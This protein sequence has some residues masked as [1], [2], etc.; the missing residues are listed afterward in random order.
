MVL[1]D[2]AVSLRSRN[3]TDFGRCAVFGIIFSAT[4]AKHRNSLLPVSC[5]ASHCAADFSS[6]GWCQ[7]EICC[8]SCMGK[9]FGERRMM[10]QKIK[11]SGFKGIIPSTTA[12]GPNQSLAAKNE[13]GQS[14]GSQKVWYSD[15]FQL[16]ASVDHQS[17][18]VH[19]TRAT[20]RHVVR[21]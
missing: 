14:V 13:R 12:Q 7:L 15:C 2:W 20:Q 6:N 8:E 9:R 18:L 11:Q 10:R 19:G 5:T 21:S 16:S 3:G 17:F 4:S 1:E